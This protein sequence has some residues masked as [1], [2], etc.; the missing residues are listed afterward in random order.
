MSLRGELPSH[1]GRL[2]G[3]SPT[4]GILLD[5][6]AAV[7]SSQIPVQKFPWSDYKARTKTSQKK[8][9]LAAVIGIGDT[10]ITSAPK[11]SPDVAT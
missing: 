5:Y 11:R 6:L 9:H 2:A 10:S 3:S 1:R 7:N 4:A 8:R